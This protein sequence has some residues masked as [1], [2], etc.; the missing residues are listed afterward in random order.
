MA[1]STIMIPLELRVAMLATVALFSHIS[2]CIAGATTTGQLAVS[3]VVVSRSSA[4]PAETL[5]RN[6]A[7]AGATTIASAP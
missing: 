7:V 5:A 1:G 3:T 4:I 6:D 2:V